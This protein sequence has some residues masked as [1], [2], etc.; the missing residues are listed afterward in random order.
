ML[1]AGGILGLF[2]DTPQA[3]FR[4]DGDSAKIEALIAERKAARMAKNFARAD[5]I[6]KSL[7]AEGILLE[8]NAAGTTWRKL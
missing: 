5:E 6:R 8:D 4:G 1:A 2:N 3:W 7:E